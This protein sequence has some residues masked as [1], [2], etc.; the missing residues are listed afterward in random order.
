M[1][2]L[3]TWYPHPPQVQVLGALLLRNMSRVWDYLN[4][5]ELPIWISLYVF[6]LYAYIVFG[7]NLNEIEPSDST[8]YANFEEFF[9]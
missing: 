5:F 2:S 6:R 3:P 1:P 4:S 8:H 9:Y 7:C